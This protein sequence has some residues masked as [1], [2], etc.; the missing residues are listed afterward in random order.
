MYCF[1]VGVLICLNIKQ[2]VQENPCEVLGKILNFFTSNQ[3]R[4]R[5]Q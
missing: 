1:L 4:L 3:L 5:E 2:R